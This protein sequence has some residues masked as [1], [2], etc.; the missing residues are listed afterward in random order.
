[1]M[2]MCICLTIVWLLPQHTAIFSVLLLSGNRVRTCAC[3]PILL[4]SACQGSYDLDE[5]IPLL[6]CFIQNDCKLVDLGQVAGARFIAGQM[7]FSRL[8]KDAG[9]EGL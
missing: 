4:S 8:G 5:L 7:R 2:Y 1:M 6:Q 9:T 3:L